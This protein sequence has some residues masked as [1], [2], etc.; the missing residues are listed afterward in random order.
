MKKILAI[1]AAG[2]LVFALAGCSASG[3]TD[4]AADNTGT[5]TESP[6]AAEPKQEPAGPTM[7]PGQKNAVAKAKNCLDLTGFSHDGLVKQLEFEKFSAEDAA[8]AADNCGA[9]WNVQA[10][11]KAA[12]YLK[13]TPLSHDGLVDQLV[14]EGFTAEQAEHGATST[15]V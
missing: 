5:A 9:D 4:K 14:F 11:K 3:A 6:K 2:A 1:A 8:F 15:G 10:E 13:L 7:T 12:D